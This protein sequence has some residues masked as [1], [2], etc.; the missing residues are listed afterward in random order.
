MPVQLNTPDMPVQRCSCGNKRIVESIKNGFLCE[1]CTYS[2]KIGKRKPHSFP[3]VAKVV[4]KKGKVVDNYELYLNSDQWQQKRQMAFSERGCVCEACYS[5]VNLCVHHVSYVN[6]RHETSADLR[7]LCHVC[8]F[9]L[10][11][12]YKKHR[13][14]KSKYKSLEKFTNNF[15]ESRHRYDKY[16]EHRNKKCVTRHLLKEMD[17]RSY[18][19]GILG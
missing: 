8:H 16:I 19:K 12:E 15:I 2:K 1:S 17:D 14:E 7:I 18:I 11:E 13:A 6:L 4:Q 5:S 9:R 10:H 3:F